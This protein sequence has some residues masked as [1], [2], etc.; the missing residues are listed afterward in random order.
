MKK[1]R[2][3]MKIKKLEKH[4][5]Y[6]ILHFFSTYI[7]STIE[8][9]F[10]NTTLLPLSPYSVRGSKLLYLGSE[11]CRQSIGS[12]PRPQLLRE[13]SAYLVLLEVTD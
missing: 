5:T 6:S 9:H 4:K 11:V 13:R 7:L 8:H 10:L 12:N 2:I 1:L 3:I